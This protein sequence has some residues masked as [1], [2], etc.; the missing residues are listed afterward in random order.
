MLFV[1]FNTNKVL[2]SWLILIWQPECPCT[3]FPYLIRIYRFGYTGPDSELQPLFQQEN[4]QKL[5]LLRALQ[6]K[7][8]MIDEETFWVWFT[9]HN[10]RACDNQVE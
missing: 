3:S 4:L 8:D 9:L 6:L 7:C 1:P 10:V 5:M 2:F